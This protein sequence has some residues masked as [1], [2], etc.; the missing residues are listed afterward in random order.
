MKL[1]GKVAVVTGARA[2][3]AWKSR[4]PSRARAAVWSSPT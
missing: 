2:A 4:K 1:N 3:S